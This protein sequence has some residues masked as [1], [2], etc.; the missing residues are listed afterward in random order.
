MNDH[1]PFT[2]RCSCADGSRRARAMVS[3]QRS[4]RIRHAL[5]ETVCV[6]WPHLRSIG[7]ATVEFGLDD[8]RD[9]DFVDQEV[10]TSP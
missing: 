10:L 8:R 3:S 7:I 4:S 6:N 1:S 5:A 9:V 2:D